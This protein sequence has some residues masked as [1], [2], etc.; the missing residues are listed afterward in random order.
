M[1]STEQVT[2]VHDY[3]S[4]RQTFEEMK[5]T[6]IEI[7]KTQRTCSAQAVFPSLRSASL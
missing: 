2:F 3:V 5:A 4:D 1:N 7:G 6:Q